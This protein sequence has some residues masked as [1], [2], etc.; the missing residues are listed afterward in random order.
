MATYLIT[1]ATSDVGC[2]LIESII[3]PRSLGVACAGL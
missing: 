3:A 2:R 1:G